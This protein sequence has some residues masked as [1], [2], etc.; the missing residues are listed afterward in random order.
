ML[1]NNKKKLLRFFGVNLQSVA[2]SFVWITSG[3]HTFQEFKMNKMILLLLGILLTQALLVFAD[4]EEL[5]DLESFESNK[6]GILNLL[7]IAQPFTS[8]D[9][10]QVNGVNPEVW[11]YEMCYVT[12]EIKTSNPSSWWKACPVPT[13]PSSY[14][15]F[16]GYRWSLKRGDTLRLRLVN[17]LPNVTSY[18]EEVNPTNLHTHGLIVRPDNLRNELFGDFIF[19]QI[20]NS[21]MGGIPPSEYK[22]MVNKLDY[23]DYEIKIPANHPN[24]LFFFHPHIEGTTQDQTQAGLVGVINIGSIT[25]YVK[26]ARKIPVKYVIFKSTQVLAS[27]ERL[28]TPDPLF[29]SPEKA[30]EDP[31]R[32]GFCMG[33]DDFSGG[34]WFFTANG[35]VFPKITIDSPHGLIIRMTQAMASM[36]CNLQ[37]I[38]SVTEEPMVFQ[39]LAVDGVSLDLSDDGNSTVMKDVLA[40]KLKVVDCGPK[41]VCAVSIYSMPSSRADIWIPQTETP[42][43]AMFRCAGPLLMGWNGDDWP[44]FDLAKVV[45]DGFASSFKPEELPIPRPGSNAIPTEATKDPSNSVGFSQARSSESPPCKKLPPGHRRRIYFGIPPPGGAGEED[46]FAL[47][48]E[49]VDGKGNVV[50]GTA[51]NMTIFN[52]DEITI[53]T[54]INSIETWEL[55]NIASEMH[56]FH[57]HQTKFRVL[58]TAEFQEGYIFPKRVSSKRVTVDNVPLKAADQGECDTV[59]SFKAG[60]CVAYPTFVE[61]PFTERGDYPYH[62]HILE[63]SDNGMMARI[64]V[65]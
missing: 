50:P 37:L 7:M 30:P 4:A 54:V 43:T 15:P 35:Q 17:R 13:I 38:S 19:V 36:T 55:V 49:E 42:S 14:H 29:C 60:D 39:V 57:I 31:P 61:I 59:D 28:V 62:C 41:R 58:E 40:K 53:C 44:T 45:F 2:F 12:N 51:K 11:A 9:W 23:A 3:C 21:L 20:F 6:N 27:G 47:A 8:P 63:H 26:R 56:N 10:L 33:I 5:V 64:R 1:R 25:N 32:K 48:Y 22:V 34:K 24:G 16:Q 52:P 18:D 46:G 65:V